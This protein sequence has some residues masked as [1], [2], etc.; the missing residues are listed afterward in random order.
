MAKVR[1]IMCLKKFQSQ[2]VKHSKRGQ[3][4]KW[5]EAAMAAAAIEAVQQKSMSHRFA[6]ETFNIT[7][8]TS[9]VCLSGK[10]EVGARPGRP[11]VTS[12]DEEQKLV[13]FACNEAAMCRIW[14]ES[15]SKVCR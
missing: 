15:I 7:R 3:H 12:R 5:N 14:S 4:L 6:C 11:T 13:D 1:K 2:A 9:H 8:C 10:T